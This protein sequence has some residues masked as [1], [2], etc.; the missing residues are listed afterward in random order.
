QI[1][2]DVVAQEV[3][4]GRQ[5]L[6]ELDEARPQ[7]AEG[8]SETLA[9]SGAAWIAATHE[10]NRAQQRPAGA[11]PLERKQRV[12]PRQGQRDADESDDMAAAAEKSEHRRDL[13]RDHSR[14]AE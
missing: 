10:A 1:L 13:S 3:G 5:Q 12:V 14:Q 11:E 4:A 8:G 7:L 9:G 2:G 6:P